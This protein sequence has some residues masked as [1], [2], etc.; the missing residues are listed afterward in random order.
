MRPKECEG[1]GG[2]AQQKRLVRAEDERAKRDE[3]SA[4]DTM[5]VETA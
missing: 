1:D 5:T 2:N 3:S 4:Y